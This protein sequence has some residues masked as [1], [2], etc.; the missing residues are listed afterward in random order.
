M[1]IGALVVP[2]VGHALGVRV[3]VEGR[4]GVLCQNDV[5]VSEQHR[6]THREEL[7]E[8]AE[9]EARRRVVVGRAASRAELP[10]VVRRVAACEEARGVLVEGDHQKVPDVGLLD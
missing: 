4:E 9:L 10:D 3:A 6:D 7:A 5:D 2:A 1:A 8:D